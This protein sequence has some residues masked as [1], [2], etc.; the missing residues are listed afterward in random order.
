MKVLKREKL[1]ANSSYKNYLFQ[2]LQQASEI[3]LIC[4]R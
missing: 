1:F 3:Y 4:L 2:A